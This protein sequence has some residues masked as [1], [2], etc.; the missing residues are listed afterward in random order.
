MLTLSGVLK[1]IILVVLSVIIWST[2]VTSL[3]ALGYTIALGGLI[4]YK[5][6]DV[7]VQAASLKLPGDK[8]STFNRRRRLSGISFIPRHHTRKARC[9]VIG[10]CFGIAITVVNMRHTF[11]TLPATSE[12]PIEELIR[13]SR[14]R[15]RENSSETV[16]HP[17]RSCSRIQNQNRD[18]PT[19]KI[20]RLV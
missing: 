15:V 1:D 2:P 5:I 13:T 11:V 9:F 4:Y 17:R 20:R 14:D 12:H 8:N 3:Q 19:S 16:S 18:V 7:R 6:D 10:L